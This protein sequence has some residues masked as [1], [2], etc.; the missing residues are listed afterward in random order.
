MPQVRDKN[1]SKMK[2]MLRDKLESKSPK[3]IMDAVK[4]REIVAEINKYG[5]NQTQIKAIIKLLSLEL[6]DRN[7]MLNIV[8]LIDNEEDTDTQKAKIEV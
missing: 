6:E 5:V 3:D 1:R 8:S 2:D 4:A 7:L